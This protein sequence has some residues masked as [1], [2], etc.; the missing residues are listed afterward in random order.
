MHL[1]NLQEGDYRIYLGA[2]EAPQARGYTAGVVV[3][4]WRGHGL[5]DGQPLELWRDDRLS[6]GHCWPSAEAAL[7]YALGKA[8]E[9]IRQRK[10]AL[11]QRLQAP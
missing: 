4:Q 5:V 11:L 7:K 8:R 2:L 3:V 9:R 10:R 1:Q 6:C